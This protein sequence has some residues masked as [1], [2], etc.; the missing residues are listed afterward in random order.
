MRAGFGVEDDGH[1]RRVMRAFDSGPQ[2]GI[3]IAE[4][5]FIWARRRSYELM[6]W[7]AGTGAPTAECLDELELGRLLLRSGTTGHRSGAPRTGF[8]ERD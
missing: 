5:A 1:P 8:Q 2:K 4:E 3:E 7:D 6:N